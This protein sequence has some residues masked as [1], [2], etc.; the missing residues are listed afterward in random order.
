MYSTD[1]ELTAR[2]ARCYKKYKFSAVASGGNPTVENALE[3]VEIGSFSSL[4]LDG[5]ASARK[6][7]GH[8]TASPNPYA[9]GI[10]MV[11][12]DINRAL[13]FPRIAG[14]PL[15]KYLMPIGTRL[16]PPLAVIGAGTFAYNIA[17]DLQCLCGVID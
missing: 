2:T 6:Y 17:T 1:P 12:K 15:A 4:S 7:I 3:Y 9:S 14:S 5:V 8:K 10:N 16:T 11:S 13:G